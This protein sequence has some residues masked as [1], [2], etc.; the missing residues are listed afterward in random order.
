MRILLALTA[1]LIAF[2]VAWLTLDWYKATLD[3]LPLTIGGPASVTDV[4]V[5]VAALPF[6]LLFNI[7]A[8][9]GALVVAVLDPFCGCGIAVAAPFL[10]ALAALCRLTSGGL[11]IYRHCR[12]WPC[13]GNTPTRVQEV[14]P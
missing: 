4:L 2:A 10:M 13:E 14:P 12:R 7:L 9:P 6:S 3:Q 11:W 8:L 5:T 1:A